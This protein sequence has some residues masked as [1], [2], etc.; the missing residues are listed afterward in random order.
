[1]NIRQMS[2]QVKLFIE[3][4]LAD[5][6][7]VLARILMNAHH[8]SVQTSFEAKF[9]RALVTLIQLYL[10]MNIHEMFTPLVSAFENFGAFITFSDF[11]T[12]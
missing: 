3:R 6:A 7:L 11:C 4:F 5:P 2:C 9:L 10:F 1:M 12:F 8:V